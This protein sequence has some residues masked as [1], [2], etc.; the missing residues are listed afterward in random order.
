[1]PMKE[2]PAAGPF[3]MPVKVAPIAGDHQHAMAT[4][5]RWLDTQ[6]AAPKVAD[7]VTRTCCRRRIPNASANHRVGHVPH[8]KRRHPGPGSAPLGAGFGRACSRG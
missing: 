5:D 7:L 2:L 6:T 1:M 3:Q 4:I 8:R